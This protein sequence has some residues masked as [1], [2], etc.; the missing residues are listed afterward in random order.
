ME[1]GLDVVSTT[2]QKLVSDA[3]LDRRWQVLDNSY[4]SGNE[5]FGNVWKNPVSQQLQRSR[6]G[7]IQK[8]RLSLS[9]QMLQNKV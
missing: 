6:S 9:I 7:K 4:K 5:M 8:Y 3:M 1:N 2:R